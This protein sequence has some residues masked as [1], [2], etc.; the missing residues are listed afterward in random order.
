M[1]KVLIIAAIALLAVACNKNQTA[2]KKLDGSWNITSMKYTSEGITQEYIGNY[3]I[4]G[5]YDFDGCKLKKDEFCKVITTMVYHED[6]GGGTDSEVNYYRV[7]SQGTK[8]EQ[9]DEENSTTVEIMEIIELT[10]SNLML[11][12]TYEDGDYFEISLDKQ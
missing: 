9:K 4:S 6:F 1:K 12:Q 10:K 2:V 5:T 11:K 3:I 8:F 7:G